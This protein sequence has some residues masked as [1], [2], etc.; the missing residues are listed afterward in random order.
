MRGIALGLCGLLAVSAAQATQRWPRNVCRELRG[1]ERIDVKSYAGRPATLA[2][3]RLDVLM[4]L[5]ERCGMDVMAKLA[6]DDAA[7]HAAAAAA[8]TSRADYRRRS[9]DPL[10]CT[11]FKIEDDMSHTLCN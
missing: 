9:R 11:T 10:Y 1:L 5:Q 3:A 4:L 6:A 7:V 2:T 8:A